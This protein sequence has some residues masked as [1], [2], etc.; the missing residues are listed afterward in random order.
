MRTAQSIVDECNGL[1]GSFYLL[2]GCVA[3]AGWRFHDSTHPIEH[4][5]WRM[6]VIAYEHIEGT[7]VESALAELNE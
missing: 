5:C 2:H 3:P 6:A 4:R 1:A 7:D